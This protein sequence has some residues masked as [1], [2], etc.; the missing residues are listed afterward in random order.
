[1][2]GA[3]IA[4]ALAGGNGRAEETYGRWCVD[5]PSA[6]WRQTM[7]AARDEHGLSYLDWLTGVDEL[8]DGFAIVAHLLDPDTMTHLLLRTRIPRDE[9][10][11][12]SVTSVHRGASWHERETA[13]MFGVVF[14]DHPNPVPLLLPEGFDGHPLRRDFVL[15]ARVAKAWPGAKEPGESDLS[16]VQGRRKLRPPGVPD[17]AWWGGQD[18]VES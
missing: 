16:A 9:P 10:R 18:E 14:D 13:E 2:N 15:V 6:E 4:A 12:A 3:E 1:V 11:L 5:V 17:P 7:Q 8:A